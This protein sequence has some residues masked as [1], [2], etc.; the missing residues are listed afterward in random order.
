MSLIIAAQLRS[1]KLLLSLEP[2]VD[3]LSYNIGNSTKLL[4]SLEPGDDSQSDNI[5]QNNFG[6]SDGAQTYVFP[7]VFAHILRIRQEVLHDLPARP[8]CKWDEEGRFE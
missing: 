8:P 7:K 2:G 1:T 3:L 4:L 5:G 6:S